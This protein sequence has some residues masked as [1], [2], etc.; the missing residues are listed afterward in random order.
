[1]GRE[2]GGHRGGVFAVH[3]RRVVATLREAN[4]AAFEE[5]DRRDEFEVFDDGLA[6]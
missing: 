4:A 6:F 3:G 2:L 1:M 5:V